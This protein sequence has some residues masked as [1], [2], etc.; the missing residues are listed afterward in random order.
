MTEN[1]S[2]KIFYWCVIIPLTLIIVYLYNESSDSEHTHDQEIMRE[3]KLSNSRV[4]NMAHYYA[5]LTA[6]QSKRH[7][8]RIV[9]IENHHKKEIDQCIKYYDLEIER[10]KQQVTAELSP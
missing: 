1:K 2:S 8:A 6:E 9:E 5:E 4:D 10:A 3:R 7:M